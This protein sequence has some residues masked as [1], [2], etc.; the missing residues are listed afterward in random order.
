M[1]SSLAH[2]LS[3][4]FPLLLYYYFVFHFIERSH[5]HSPKKIKKRNGE[6]YNSMFSDMGLV[7]FVVTVLGLL[8]E[9]RGPNNV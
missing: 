8:E 2:Y 6:R 1:E 9:K 7:L 5:F 3:M 4:C